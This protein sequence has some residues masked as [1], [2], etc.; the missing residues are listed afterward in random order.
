[1]LD[2]ASISIYL[3]SFE[4]FGFLLKD[5][6]RKLTEKNKVNLV[7]YN[8]FLTRLDRLDIAE[9]TRNDKDKWDLFTGLSQKTK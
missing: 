4:W 6:E 8:L 9:I 2:F 1:M 3:D 7:D 5:L